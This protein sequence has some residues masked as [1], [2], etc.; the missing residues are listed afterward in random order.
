MEKEKL[1]VA[2]G[3]KEIDGAIQKF[4]KYETVGTVVYK[5]KLEETCD[6]LKPD[7]LLT[8]EMLNGQEA[9]APILLKVKTKHPNLRIVYLSG[10]IDLKNEKEVNILSLLVMAGVFDIIHEKTMTFDMLIKALNTPKNRE[11]VE[12]ILKAA[13]KSLGQRKSS[14]EIEFIIPEEYKEEDENIRN[15]LFTISSIKPG[16]GKSFVSVNVAT[17]IAQYGENLPN[18]KRPRVGLIEADLQ[19]LSLGTLLQ[20]EDDE[21]NIKNA[22]TKISEIISGTG[23]LYGTARDI[24]EVN[25]YLK[26]SFV[27]YYHVRNLKALVGSQF[28]LEELEGVTSYHY[29]YLVDAVIDEFDVLI[30]DTN[31]ALTHVTTF[32]LLHMSKYAY[33]ILNLDFNN[34]RNNLRYKETLKNM[35]INDKVKYILNEDIPG[36]YLKDSSEELIFTAEHLEDSGFKLEARIPI[37]PKTIFLNRLYEGTPIV[38]DENGKNDNIRYEIFKIANQIYPIKDFHKIEEKINNQNHKSKGFF[39]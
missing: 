24:E 7:I 13:E 33:Y 26:N 21:K 15:N 3:S 6:L 9:L 14:K 22:M 31:S 19:N 11:D 5:D 8:T 39:G 28:T 30:V 38:L 1:L 17:A 4:P 23:E 12:F 37:I 20:I 18:G 25:Y 36:G 27:P 10:E 35:G 16:T 32:P 34:V 29:S 2:T